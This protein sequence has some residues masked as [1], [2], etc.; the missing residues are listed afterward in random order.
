MAQKTA[1]QR[2]SRNG[3]VPK[4]SG[5]ELPAPSVG[6]ERKRVNFIIPHELKWS[7]RYRMLELESEGRIK[8]K[9]EGYTEYLTW[10]IE[11]DLAEARETP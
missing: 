4:A 1:R 8:P 3:D 2:T 9:R 11:R 6:E 5:Y 7:V 10:L